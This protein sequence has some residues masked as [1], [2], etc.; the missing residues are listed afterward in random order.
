MERKTTVGIFQTKN[1]R[2]LTREELDM[3]MKG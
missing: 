3:T 1:W 2:N